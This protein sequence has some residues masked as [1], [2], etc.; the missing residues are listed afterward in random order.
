LKIILRCYLVEGAEKNHPMPVRIAG[1]QPNIKFMSD[2]EGSSLLGY[3][4]VSIGTPRP[5]V[6]PH[7]SEDETSATAL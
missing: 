4:T 3:D 5:R 6:Q 7:I 2:V 1:S